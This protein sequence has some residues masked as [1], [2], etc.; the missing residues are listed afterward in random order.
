[1]ATT[2]RP[3]GLLILAGAIRHLHLE[4]QCAR[5]ETEFED[6][7]ITLRLLGLLA[8]GWT[9]GPGLLNVA[10]AYAV[11]IPHAKYLRRRAERAEFERLELLRAIPDY[12]Y[13]REPRLGPDLT[14]GR[15]HLGS[16]HRGDAENARAIKEASARVGIAEKTI[17]RRIR[18]GWTFEKATSEPS[19]QGSKLYGNQLRNLAGQAIEGDDSISTSGPDA[20]DTPADQRPG[21][22]PA[23]NRRDF[24]PSRAGATGQA[25][26]L[27]ADRRIPAKSVRSVAQRQQI[28]G[29][30]ARVLQGVSYFGA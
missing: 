28:A 13:S 10:C 24:V 7:S 5:S 27:A 8:D 30:R 21:D 1:M 29:V 17:Y 11:G 26:L 12:D 15:R 19:R 9:G 6:Y 2:A 20:N 18:E 16:V 4:A 22:W 25:S 23:P 14:D 3:K